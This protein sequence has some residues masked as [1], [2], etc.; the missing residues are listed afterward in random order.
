MAGTP[1]A[2]HCARPLANLRD[3]CAERSSACV[4]CVISWLCNTGKL[5]IPIEATGLPALLLGGAA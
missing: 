4:L 3:F 5:C 2:S 1:F